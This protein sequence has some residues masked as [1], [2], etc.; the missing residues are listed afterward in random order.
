MPTAKGAAVVERVDPDRIEVLGGNPGDKERYIN[1]DFLIRSGMCPNGHGLMTLGGWGHA[2]RVGAA[3]SDDD[4]KLQAAYEFAVRRDFYRW[5]VIP[6]GCPTCGERI[7]HWGGSADR[8]HCPLIPLNVH[9][10]EVRPNCMQVRR[11]RIGAA[12]RV[13]CESRGVS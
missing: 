10:E 11:H 8:E 6:D 2:A 7:G 1:S 5:R 4:E 13:A 9:L 12:I 3:M